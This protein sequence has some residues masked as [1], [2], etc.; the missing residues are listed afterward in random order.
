MPKDFSRALRIADQ[1]QRELADLLRHEVKD[2]RVGSIT[3]TAV[4]VTRDYGHAKIYYTTLGS[5]GENSLVEEGLARASGFLRSQLSHR[6]KLRI[7]P[8]L[9]FA[10]DRS[11][12]QGAK[13]SSLIDEAISQEGDSSKKSTAD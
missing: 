2:P 5:D 6:M 3:I 12:E 4:D 13:L 11:I 8:Q 10:Y 7:V 9:H 1:I